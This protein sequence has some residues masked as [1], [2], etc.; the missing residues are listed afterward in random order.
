[1]LDGAL[2]M[3]FMEFSKAS[4]LA[5]SNG[6]ARVVEH[7]IHGNAF[8]WTYREAVQVQGVGAVSGP[9]GTRRSTD[10]GQDRGHKAGQQCH[11]LGERPGRVL[12][13]GT[14][15]SISYPSCDHTPGCTRDS[16]SDR[17]RA[18][19]SAGQQTG[20]A[21]CHRGAA[22]EHRSPRPV[23]GTAPDPGPAIDTVATGDRSPRDPGVGWLELLTQRRPGLGQRRPCPSLIANRLCRG[24]AQST[25]VPYICPRGSAMSS[26]RAPSGSRKY[27]E[28]P[29]SIW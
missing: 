17:A 29:L 15:R 13:A 5:A 16:P 4:P 10:T 18:G 6:R 8:Q 3:S 2:A 21:L 12:A 7:R 22:G 20:T 23:V 14:Y 9:A 19:R 1:M 24:E 26:R 25:L 28:V 11:A 27:T